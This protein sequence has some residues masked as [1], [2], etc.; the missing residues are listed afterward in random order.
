MN[1]ILKFLGNIFL[2][3]G[4]DDLA[5]RNIMAETE[6]TPKDII[7]SCIEKYRTQYISVLSLISFFELLM[8]VRGIA[9]FDFTKP[10]RILYMV[11]YVSLL[12]F[13]LLGIY[14]MVQAQKR[15]KVTDTEES[16]VY[17]YC[18]FLTAWSAGISML[19]T[20]G[21]HTPIVFMTVIMGTAALAFIKPAVFISIV[22]VLSVGVAYCFMHYGNDYVA[23]SGNLIN[24]S[25][26]IVF[27]YLISARLFNQNK[28]DYIV[29][30]K[31][32]SLSYHDQ[33]TGLKNRYALQND[34]AKTKGMIYF[35]IFDF[36]N[37]KLIN[38]EHGHDFGDVCLQSVANLLEEN[39]QDSAYRYG[40]DEFVIA[41]RMVQGEIQARCESINAKLKE[42]YPDIQVQLSGGFYCP[43]T[44]EESYADYLR[45]SDRALYMAK[46]NGKGKF[47]FY[48]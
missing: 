8:I 17:A 5:L 14:T 18:I 38:D 29:M 35:G 24:F 15:G 32:E 12:V 45:Y 42:I 3:N 26:F 2:I 10:R 19:D 34:M 25:I 30:T 33:L 16:I 28:A 4:P 21:G 39:F 46:E 47:V 48:D 11:C 7:H 1:K 31:L 22:T 41:T 43:K 36:D 20:F 40:G 6:V 27:T 9:Y 13:S 37:F 44:S 23:S